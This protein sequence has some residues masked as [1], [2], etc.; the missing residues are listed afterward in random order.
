MNTAWNLGLAAIWILSFS[1]FRYR[2]ARAEA[3]ESQKWLAGF[4]GTGWTKGRTA[5]GRRYR[6]YALVALVVGG[7][8]FLLS[9]IR[10][11]GK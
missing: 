4:L 1:Y 6:R 2:A 10:P 5:D 3:P 9:P 7:G 8:L 11:F